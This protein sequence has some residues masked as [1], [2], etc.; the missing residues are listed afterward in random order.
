MQLISFIVSS[1]TIFTLLFAR[2]IAVV[3]SSVLDNKTDSLSYDTKI[4]SEK[5]STTIY[6][7]SGS[8]VT[9]SVNDGVSLHESLSSSNGVDHHVG[10]TGLVFAFAAGFVA[11]L[12]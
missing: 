6:A 2:T 9:E 7:D 12:L 3:D 1:F 5:I 8:G 4:E 11:L 10:S